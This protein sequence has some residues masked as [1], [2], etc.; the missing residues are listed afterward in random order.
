MA[1]SKFI[2]SES[3]FH[4][5]NGNIIEGASLGTNVVAKM[6][7]TTGNLEVLNL[8]E[9]YNALDAIGWHVNE[10]GQR[11]W[12]NPTSQVFGTEY[13]GGSGNW[14][15]YKQSK[16][17]TT[18]RKYAGKDSLYGV[19]IY[20]DPNVDSSST[21]GGLSFYP[22]AACKLRNHKYRLSFDYRG[23][24]NGNTMEVYNNYTVGWGDMGIGLPTPWW[25]GVG[26]YDTDWEWRRYEYDYEIQDQYLDFVPGSNRPAWSPTTQYT[27][28]Y[29]AVT[30]NGYVYAHRA[31]Y[32]DPTL[33]VNP[34]AEYPGTWV[35]KVPM[36]AGYFD[37]YSNIKIG[38]SYEA[39]GNRG[40]HIYLDNIQITDI[41]NNSRWK[42]N[43]S[44][45]EAD[46]IAEKTTHIFAKGTAYMGIDKGDGGDKF[47]VEGSRVLEINGTRVYE[48]SGRGL[49]LTVINEL[50][51]SV[52]LDQLFDTY[53]SD[54]AR[55]D[56]ANALA[57]IGSDQLWVLT[58]F[59]AINPNAALDSQMA[60]MGS[61]LL[62]NDGNE[63]SVY[64][65]GG[66]RSTYAAVGRG[67][68]LIKEDGAT[69]GDTVYKRKA[70]IDLK[71]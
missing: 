50:D 29:Y 7:R 33:G 65:N 61:I 35:W 31:G 26:A 3:E 4:I 42:F 10:D 71:L 14:S 39:Q 17:Y 66:Y 53:G 8:N 45:W 34:E 23:Y 22:P 1:H 36:T 68:K 27:G 46:N 58:S 16:I 41:T 54:P 55:T 6:N 28:S 11:W 62:V 51:N 44:G 70:V 57:S 63:Y 56:L 18:A 13:G 19:H 52:V 25:A 12:S 37:L 20:R 69:Q 49:R 47:A 59:D 21:W 5:E 15:I 9:T 38:F 64:K 32:P 60:S 24:T 43:G 2:Q 30:Y 67:Q 48:A 40:T